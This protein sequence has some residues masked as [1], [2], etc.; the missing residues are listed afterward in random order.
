M[1]DNGAFL[2]SFCAYSK[3]KNLSVSQNTLQCTLN[4]V[5]GYYLNILSY[6][7]A[8]LKIWL[9]KTIF[10]GR[11]TIPYILLSTWKKN[12]WLH[13]SPVKPLVHHAFWHQTHQVTAVQELI[14]LNLLKHNKAYMMTIYVTSC[15][16][17]CHWKHGTQT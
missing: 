13:V 11:I 14:K 12:I 16:C 9:K 17:C 3:P 7:W 8:N 5:L 10:S 15:S 2:W 6:F 4:L 1:E